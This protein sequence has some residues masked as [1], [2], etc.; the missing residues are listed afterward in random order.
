YRVARRARAE[1]LQRQRHQR[2]LTDLPVADSVVDIAWREVRTV[3]DEEVCELPERYRLPI[4]LC[5]LQGLTK[6]EA[7]RQLGW[8][9]G[10]LSTRLHAARLRLRQRLIR[11]GLTLAAG[12][13]ALVLAEGSGVACPPSA[14]EAVVRIAAGGPVSSRVTALKEGALQTMLFQKV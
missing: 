1:A 5:L 13:L 12:P 11:R 14:V 10:T 8:P 2:P 4:V 6:G 3:I 9:E 7:A